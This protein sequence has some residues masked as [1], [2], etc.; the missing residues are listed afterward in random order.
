M[1]AVLQKEAMHTSFRFKLWRRRMAT[2]EAFIIWRNM[3]KMKGRQ[4][5]REIRRERAEEVAGRAREREKGGK[6][7]R[8]G[9]HKAK[10]R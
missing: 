6:G 9:G 4:K 8:E 5:K 2:R 10:L 7:G 3:E 1:M